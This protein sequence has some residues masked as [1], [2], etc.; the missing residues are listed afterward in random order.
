[1]AMDLASGLIHDRTILCCLITRRPRPTVLDRF[2][3]Q[4]LG[5]VRTSADGEF[6]AFTDRG[7]RPQARLRQA[8]LLRY[9]RRHAT[10]TTDLT[11]RDAT[12]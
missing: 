3:L 1:M 8:S 9:I 12:L 2:T 6:T 5:S 4:K 10:G 7:T 11:A